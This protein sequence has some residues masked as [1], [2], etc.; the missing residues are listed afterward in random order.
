MKREEYDEETAQGQE[1]IREHRFKEWNKKGTNLSDEQLA[2]L[3]ETSRRDWIRSKSSRAVRLGRFPEKM[4]QARSDR[5]NEVKK[6][7]R[8]GLADLAALSFTTAP[9]LK[10]PKPWIQEQDAR[11]ILDQGDL[12]TV[13]RYTVDL[14]GEAYAEAIL[15]AVAPF[16]DRKGFKIRVE[17]TIRGGVW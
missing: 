5:K 9:F 4:G 2:F 1:Q 7:L 15:Q 12:V 6:K 14:F 11:A 13:V 10:D 17:K 8:A 3:L 16:Y